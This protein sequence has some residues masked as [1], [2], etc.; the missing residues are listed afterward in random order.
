MP[1]YMP[2]EITD[3][4]I[5]AVPL[6]HYYDYRPS[7]THTLAMCA[8]VC[9]AWLPRSRVE[10]FKDIL[11]LDEHTYDLLVERVLHSETMSRYLASVNS[12]GLGCLGKPDPRSKAARLFFVEFA[13]KLP[14]LRTL[15]VHHIDFTHQRPSVRWPLLL[16]QFRTITS[17]RLWSCR[18]SS[19]SDVRR[20]LTALPLLST[21]AIS[22]LTWPVVSHELH[23]QTTLRPR[24]FWPELHTLGIHD[25]STECAAVFL[26]WIVGALHGSPVK[27]LDCDFSNLPSTGPLQEA[28]DAFMGRV[29]PSVTDLDM[30]I[31]DTLP[32]SGFIALEH[33]SCDLIVYKGKWEG[34]ASVL[35]G[36]S[37]N[38][39]QSIIFNYVYTHRWYSR[40]NINTTYLRFDNDTLEELD[41]V[42]SGEPFG[43]LRDVILRVVAE[44]EEEEELIRAHARRCLPE[45]HKRRILHLYVNGRLQRLDVE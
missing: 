39:I 37:S 34:V 8:L 42:L 10:L 31:N 19:F 12:L 25:L 20:L 1:P 26:R 43:G 16:S 45:L 15:D 23:L 6:E 24:T 3:T 30:N 9:R 17:L 38:T 18:F 2:R 33:L 40:H 36:V 27:V 7:R 22:Q 5:S 44:K 21:L 13:G 4:I 41:R 35:Q 32:L 28:V 14:G 29:G 11:I